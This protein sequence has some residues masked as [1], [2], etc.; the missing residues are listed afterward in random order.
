[1]N[2]PDSPKKWKTGKGR[3]AWSP[4]R[5][6]FSD[7]F[8]QKI[9]VEHSNPKMY[10]SHKKTGLRSEMSLLKTSLIPFRANPQSCPYIYWGLW[11]SWWLGGLFPCCGNSMKY[12]NV[13]V[14]LRQLIS[15][16]P[17]AIALCHCSVL[18][19][20]CSCHSFVFFPCFLLCIDCCWLYYV[21]LWVCL[22]KPLHAT[23]VVSLSPPSI[24]HI[25]LLFRRAVAQGFWFMWLCL[26][27]CPYSCSCYVPD[28][29]YTSIPIYPDPSRLPALS[30]FSNPPWKQQTIDIYRLIDDWLPG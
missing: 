22:P 9:D 14:C 4:Q 13:I 29:W 19:L 8:F 28:C 26:R 1:M 2:T 11:A 30:H 27:W 18:V 25:H 24:W 20:I 3:H 23:I 16:E 5:V 6:H 17:N 15:G 21:V 12:P 10:Q 7:R